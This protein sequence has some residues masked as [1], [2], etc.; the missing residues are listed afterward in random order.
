M[1]VYNNW[2]ISKAKKFE[3][4]TTPSD[5]GTVLLEINV[6]DGLKIDAT[7][8]QWEQIVSSLASAL[9]GAKAKPSKRDDD[10]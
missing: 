6:Y 5:K 1:S 8:E 7:P 9:G 2:Y 3:V 4:K 10:Y